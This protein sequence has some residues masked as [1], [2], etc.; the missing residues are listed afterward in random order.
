MK[1]KFIESLSEISSVDFNQ[2]ID[3]KDKPFMSYEYLYALEQ[4]KSV[5]AN[6]GWQSFHLTLAEKE[7]LSGFIPIYK[8][9]NSHGEF[10]FDYQYCIIW[11]CYLDQGYYIRYS[12]VFSIEYNKITSL[13]FVIE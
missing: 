6:N 13:V 8:K 4:S 9:N 12:C 7:D 3:E 11:V 2:I 5:H 1:S 10:V